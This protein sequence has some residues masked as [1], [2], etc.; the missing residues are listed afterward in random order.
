[1]RWSGCGL[2]VAAPSRSTAMMLAPVRSRT[3]ASSS[4][5]P[6]S[7]DEGSTFIHSTESWPS[8]MSMD[9]AMAGWK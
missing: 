9:S 3:R 6:A 5:M 4:V 2:G 7:G 8:T 1:M